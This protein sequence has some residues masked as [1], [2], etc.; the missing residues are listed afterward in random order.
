MALPNIRRKLSLSADKNNRSLKDI[1]APMGV[2]IEVISVET[3]STPMYNTKA[4]IRTD[5]RKAGQ[6]VTDSNRYS[7]RTV[8]YNRINIANVIPSDYV[9]KTGVVA[10]V[11]EDLNVNHQCDFTTDDIEISGGKIIAKEGSLGYCNAVAVEGGS[12]VTKTDQMNFNTFLNINNAPQL[13]TL[14]A[15]ANVRIM[16]DEEV[17]VYDLGFTTAED[18]SDAIA[19][20]IA[21]VAADI[22]QIELTY[23]Y[24]IDHLGAQYELNGTARVYNVSGG[25][26]TVKNLTDKVIGIGMVMMY[27]DNKMYTQLLPYIGLQPKGS[28]KK[29]AKDLPY[30]VTTH[31]TQDEEVGYPKTW[32]DD[33]DLP[34]NVDYG[35]F[36]VNGVATGDYSIYDKLLNGNNLID[37]YTPSMS[38]CGLYF[39]HNS[40][41]MGVKDGFWNVDSAYKSTL[42]N[43]SYQPITVEI[44]GKTYELGPFPKTMDFSEYHSLIHRWQIYGTLINNTLMGCRINLNGEEY[45]LV[46]TETDVWHEPDTLILKLFNENPEL[47]DVLKIEIGGV[48][49]GG[50]LV[51]IFVKNLTNEEIT[52]S[53]DIAHNHNEGLNYRVWVP[54]IKIAGNGTKSSEWGYDTHFKFRPFPLPKWNLPSLPGATVN[55]VYY[56]KVGKV[57]EGVTYLAYVSH[58]GGVFTD[59]DQVH[60]GTNVALMPVEV[61]V[62]PKH[63]GYD[64][65]VF[66]PA[67]CPYPFINYLDGGT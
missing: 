61:K 63:L 20:L 57:L 47:R 10:D 37:Y 1:I 39:S 29:F 25:N 8:V 24:R 9:V 41:F 66:P 44:A 35:R 59:P 49:A 42:I 17:Y 64:S 22:P 43:Y 18:P 45:S 46:K 58:I 36:K 7:Q 38:S 28:T 19:T 4:V 23:N 53:L 62:D 26:F 32:E 5:L 16:V 14:V 40:Y 60:L 33:T 6:T 12:E 48:D 11:V 30:M 67:P 52:F 27:E 50:Y 13:P 34:D 55:G 65:F 51:S 31:R 15:D 54:P 56:D 2:G 3:I 21:K